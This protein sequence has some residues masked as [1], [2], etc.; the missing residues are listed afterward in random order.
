MPTRPT[1]PPTA[2]AGAGAAPTWTAGR[3]IALVAGS[4]VLLGSVA[5][6]LAGGALAV[7]DQ[8]MR[9]DGY[10]MS[11]TTALSTDTYALASTSVELHANAPAALMPERL[12]GDVKVTAESGSAPIFLGIARTADANAYLSGVEHATVT[13]LNGFSGR[14]AYDTSGSTAPATPPASRDIWVA[15]S[16]GTGTQQVVWPAE[17]GDWTVVVMRADGTRGV[18]ASVAAGATVPALDWLVP[19]LLVSAGLGLALAIGLLVVALHTSHRRVDPG[20]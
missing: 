20:V 5:V 19:T 9:E 13:D 15:Q 4:L 14:P 3:I 6:G 12:L 8:T 17:N 16:T 11:G 2:T 10:L 18:A 1:T 7:A